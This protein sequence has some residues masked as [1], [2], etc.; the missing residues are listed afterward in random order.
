MIKLNMIHI[1]CVYDIVEEKMKK[2]FSNFTAVISLSV[3]SS[4]Q[5]FLYVYAR[6]L[7]LSISH[8]IFSQICSNKLNHF[9]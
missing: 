6:S 8:Y 2:E 1:V 3:F 4:L 5:R 7:F 9:F